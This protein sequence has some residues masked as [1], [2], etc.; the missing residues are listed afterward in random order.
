M[1]D[2]NT[3]LAPRIFCYLCL[4]LLPRVQKVHR[5]GQGRE[6]SSRPSSSTVLAFDEVEQCNEF[7]YKLTFSRENLKENERIF[8]CFVVVVLS[9]NEGRFVAALRRKKIS[10][11]QDK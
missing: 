7:Y 10:I 11:F 5:M 6:L 3:L 2:L 8:S 4:P 9:V 1:D